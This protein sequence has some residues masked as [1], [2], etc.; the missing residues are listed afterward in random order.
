MI[1]ENFADELIELVQERLDSMAR[2][3]T[4]EQLAERLGLSRRSVDR[5]VEKGMPYELY[6]GTKRFDLHEVKRWARAH[7]AAVPKARKGRG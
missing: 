4:G 5:C 7:P 3:L 1:T 6:N 2:S